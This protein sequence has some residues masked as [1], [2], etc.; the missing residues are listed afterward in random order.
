MN[1]LLHRLGIQFKQSSQWLLYCDYQSEGYTQSVTIPITHDGGIKDVK[2]NTKWT[3]RG[4]LSLYNLLKGV[5]V[6]PHYRTKYT[7]N[8][9]SS[10]TSWEWFL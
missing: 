6:V 9:V 8:D 1:N 7:R 3:Q 10:I 5:G 4:R 2:M